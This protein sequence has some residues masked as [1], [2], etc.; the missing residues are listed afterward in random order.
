MSDC[1]RCHQCGTR[2]RLVLDGE[3]WCPTCQTFRRYRSHG[4]SRGAGTASEQA[5]CPPEPR[6]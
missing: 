4:W 6:P 2:L 5:P 1:Q 3:E